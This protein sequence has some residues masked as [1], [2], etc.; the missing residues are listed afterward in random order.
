[1]AL[2]CAFLR[3]SLF[4]NSLSS[5]RQGALMG[6]HDRQAGFLFSMAAACLNAIGPAASKTIRRGPSTWYAQRRRDQ[7]LR[8]DGQD[9]R[10]GSADIPTV[11]EAGTAGGGSMCRCG[12]AGFPVSNLPTSSS[13]RGQLQHRN[14]HGD[15]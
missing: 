9:T 12:A 6:K 5:R 7:G 10:G 14:A 4:R 11:D 13:S 3:F 2:I 15:I 8:R 1:M